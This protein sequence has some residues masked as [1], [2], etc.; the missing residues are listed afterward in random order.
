MLFILFRKRCFLFFLHC[1]RTDLSSF[2]FVWEYTLPRITN[3]PMSKL[4]Y[5]SGMWEAQVWVFSQSDLKHP[6][7]MLSQV[8]YG[9]SW[10]LFPV[11]DFQLHIHKY[12]FMGEVSNSFGLLG[13]IQPMVLLEGP[14]IG[15]VRWPDMGSAIKFWCTGSCMECISPVVRGATVVLSPVASW[16]HSPCCWSSSRSGS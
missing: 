11:G 6:S 16:Y 7:W 3:N 1:V 8:T 10:D 13:Q 15:N 2:D 14:G 9:L 12:I 5:S 4:Q